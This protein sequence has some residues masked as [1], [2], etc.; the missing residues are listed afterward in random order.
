MR[1]HGSLTGNCLKQC[2]SKRCTTGRGSSTTK[3]GC[4]ELSIP[5]SIS[6]DGFIHDSSFEFDSNIKSGK[7]KY[8]LFNWVFIE[9]KYNFGTGFSSR[10]FDLPGK[11]VLED[12]RLYPAEDWRHNLQKCLLIESRNEIERHIEKNL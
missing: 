9:K 1:R 11:L 4:N 7:G 6:A 3:T 8:S 10:M 12:L 5:P 2:L